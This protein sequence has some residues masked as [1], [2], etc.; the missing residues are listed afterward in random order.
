M[1]SAR[2]VQECPLRLGQVCCRRLRTEAA[3]PRP[4]CR[5]WQRRARPVPR[6]AVSV[7][8]LQCAWRVTGSST[9]LV[10]CLRETRETTGDT[11]PAL[12]QTGAMARPRALAGQLGWLLLIGLTLG[13][14]CGNCLDEP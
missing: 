14:S 11:G 7:S 4:S 10:Q 8:S 9:E 5:E 3:L 2:W 13:K 1:Q 12:G 6:A